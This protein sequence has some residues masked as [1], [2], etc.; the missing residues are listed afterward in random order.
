MRVQIADRDCHDEFKRTWRLHHPLTG[1]QLLFASNLGVISY[2]SFYHGG[3]ELYVI[4]GIPGIW[5]EVCISL[6]EES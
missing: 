2:V 3:D 6:A 4:D 1:E 5:H